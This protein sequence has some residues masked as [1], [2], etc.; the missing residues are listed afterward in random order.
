MDGAAIPWNAS[1][2]DY[3]R[4]HSA[5]VVEALEQPLLLPKDVDAAR[6]LKQHELFMS[7]KRDLAMVSSQ[8]YTFIYLSINRFSLVLT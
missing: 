6:K 4:G 1:I 8:S 5:Y 2:W 7:L 3:Q